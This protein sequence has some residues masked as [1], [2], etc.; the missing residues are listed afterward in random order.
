MKTFDLKKYGSV[1]KIRLNVTSYMEGN[2]AITMAS[3]E[4]GEAEPWNV[5]TV[6]LD[7]VRPR[8]CAFIDTN[9]NGEDILAWIIRPGLAVPTGTYGRSGFCRY[10]EYRFRPEVLQEIDPDGYASYLHDWEERY[11]V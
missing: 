10:P 4:N 7:S 2:L 9:N 5:L 11:G 6:N 1:Y 3:W 8:N